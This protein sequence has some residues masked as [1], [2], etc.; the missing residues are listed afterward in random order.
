MAAFHPSDLGD[1]RAIR[2]ERPDVDAVLILG[3]GDQLDAARTTCSIDDAGGDLGQRMIEHV[4][5]VEDL[6]DRL[7]CGCGEQRLDHIVDVHAIAALRSVS[8][9]VDLSPDKPLRMKT[10]QEANSSLVNR[11]RGP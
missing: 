5:D 2:V 9:D 11:W 3:P 6:A 1:A 8:E 7:G 10:G 4:A